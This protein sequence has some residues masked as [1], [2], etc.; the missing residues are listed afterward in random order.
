MKKIICLLVFLVTSL[1]GFA[2][3]TNASYYLPDGHQYNSEIPTP[4]SILGFNVGD[5]HVSHD[6]LS[7]YMRVLASSSD[8]ISIKNRGNTYEGRPLLLLTITN[9]K[10]HQNIDEIKKKH[11]QLSEPEGQNLDL[12]SMP[13]VVYQGFSI[14][15]NEPSGANSGLMVAYH[16]AASEDASVIEL[17]EDVVILFDPSFNPDGL[18]RFSQWANTHKSNILNPDPNDR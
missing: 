1:T 3:T 10:N 7:E 13:A 16:L 12:S 17:L 2:Q 11:M 18:Q 5:W 15:G 6:K 8:R 14:H 4:Q 9:P